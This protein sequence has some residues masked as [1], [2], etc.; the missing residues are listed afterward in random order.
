MIITLI[1]IAIFVLGIVSFTIKGKFSSYK[2]ITILECIGILCTA[3]GSVLG[4]IMSSCLIYFKENH[5]S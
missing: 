4:L 2:I 5:L 3:T 1:V